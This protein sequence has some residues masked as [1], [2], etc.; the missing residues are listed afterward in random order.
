[1]IFLLK[2]YQKM[3]IFGS[4]CRYYPS[5][6]NYAIEALDKHGTLK[7]AGLTLLRLLKCNQFFKGGFDPVS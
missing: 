2:L 1:M 4:R 7:G 6:S 5:C 3:N